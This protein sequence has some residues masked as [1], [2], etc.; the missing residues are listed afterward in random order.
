MATPWSPQLAP[1]WKH[2]PLT[3]VAES[4]ATA[5]AAERRVEYCIFGMCWDAVRFNVEVGDV[6]VGVGLD[7]VSFFKF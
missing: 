2:A 3:E 7:M 6:C 5:A 1:D 4:S